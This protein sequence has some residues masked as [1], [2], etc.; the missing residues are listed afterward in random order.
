[1]TH[2]VSPSMNIAHLRALRFVYDAEDDIAIIHFGTPQGVITE[3][4]NE[5]L[6]L[7]LAAESGEVVGLEMHGFQSRFLRNPYLRES[8]SAGIH[9][10]ES[11]SGAPFGGA[12]LVYEGSV[13]RLPK[14][15]HLTLLL[16]GLAIGL[17]DTNIHSNRSGFLSSVPSS[18]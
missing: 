9:E 4:V 17:Y 8:F 2:G 16:V 3:Q 12:D 6:F 11:S 7:R 1:M 18:Y 14:T 15:T 10:L 13:E 5:G